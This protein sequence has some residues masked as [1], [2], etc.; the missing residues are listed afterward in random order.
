MGPKAKVMNFTSPPEGHFL[1]FFEQFRPFP[2]AS[3]PE[4]AFPFHHHACG[5]A[6]GFILGSSAGTRPMKDMRWDPAGHCQVREE[7][8]EKQAHVDGSPADGGALC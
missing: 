4:A 1:P 2:D 6:V 7:Y 5:G 3:G 8:D